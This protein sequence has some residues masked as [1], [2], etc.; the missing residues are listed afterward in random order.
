MVAYTHAGYRGRTGAYQIG[1]EA[2]RKPGRTHAMNLEDT[3]HRGRH[4]YRALCGERVAEGHSGDE[5]APNVIEPAG[6]LRVTCRRCL[7]K[8]ARGGA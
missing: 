6:R 4:I 2:R 7:A 3:T 5:Y 8:I 1:G